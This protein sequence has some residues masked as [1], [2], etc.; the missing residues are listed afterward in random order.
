MWNEHIVLIHAGG[1]WSHQE[2]LDDLLAA[3]DARRELVEPAVGFTVRRGLA[4]VSL[5][6]K[7]DAKATAREIASR[8]LVEEMGQLGLV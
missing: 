3:L 5:W 1:V 7:A 8:A 2:H 4:A 6:V